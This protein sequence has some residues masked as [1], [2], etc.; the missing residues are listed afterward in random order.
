MY[1]ALRKINNK[2]N[3]PDFY[4]NFFCII[5]E[6][7]RMQLKNCQYSSIGKNYSVL[8]DS[9]NRF[10]KENYD[11]NYSLNHSNKE[12]EIMT[13]DDF[14]KLSIRDRMKIKDEKFEID[15]INS[16]YD[17]LLKIIQKKIQEGKLKGKKINE[18]EHDLYNRFVIDEFNDG[19]CK[20]LFDNNE[21]FIA[22]VIVR[23]ER[24][25][26]LLEKMNDYNIQVSN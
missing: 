3:N 19:L 16:I 17:D 2:I 7:K 6:L 26:D 15:S 18:K 22:L 11:L 4:F 24:I 13:I 14:K 10:F 20:N 5:A 9:I 12:N 25:A 21:I 1:S 23:Q 8:S